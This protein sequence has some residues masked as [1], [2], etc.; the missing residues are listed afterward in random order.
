MTEHTGFN[1][2][3]DEGAESALNEAESIVNDAADVLDAN[4]DGHISAEELATADENAADSALDHAQETA[5]EHLADL[6]RLQAEYINYRKR[7][8]RKSVV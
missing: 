4:N 1:T 8:D 3:D 2:P 5:K 7:V 6:Q